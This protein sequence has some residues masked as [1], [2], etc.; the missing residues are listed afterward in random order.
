MHIFPANLVSNMLSLQ[1]CVITFANGIRINE[2]AANEPHNTLK[3][4]TRSI[5]VFESQMCRNRG[6]THG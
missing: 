4:N 5:D 6:Y 3:T 2:Y 1:H